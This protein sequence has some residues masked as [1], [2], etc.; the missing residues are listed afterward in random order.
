M[1]IIANDNCN[2]K[3][4]EISLIKEIDEVEVVQYL[5]TSLQIGILPILHQGAFY[6]NLQC[7]QED[8]E[9]GC[10]INAF[11]HN[12]LTPLMLA[13]QSGHIEI[14]RFLLLC[15]A[16]THASVGK[17]RVTSLHL[18]VCNGS[19]LIV[20]LLLEYCANVSQATSLECT[21]LHMAAY[22]GDML[23]ARQLLQR[24]ADPFA[25]DASD[26]SVL[27]AA[28]M[29]GHLDFVDMLLTHVATGMHMSDDYSY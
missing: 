7:V 27:S 20:Q 17:G 13:T 11:D 18:A 15:G 25:L 22:S 4:N 23:V 8:I 28:E 6:G 16:D 19:H 2:R 5:I 14:V 9:K 24:G 12:G 10:D 29:G 1:K 3:N 21:P 26:R